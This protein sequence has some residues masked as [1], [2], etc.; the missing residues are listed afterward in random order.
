MRP[1]NVLHDWDEETVGKLIQKSFDALSPGGTLI[2]HDV[3]INEE[4]T[5]PLP[6]AAY[7]A[8]LMHA[9]EG[10]CYSTGEYYSALHHAGFRDC[11]FKNTAADRSI[12]TAQKPV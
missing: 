4:K 9:T 10:K 7:S 1:R 6:N 5:G 12:I 8:L 2:I 11:A 3:M